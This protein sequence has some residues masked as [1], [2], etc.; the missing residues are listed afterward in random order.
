MQGVE[1]VL[2]LCSLPTTTSPA[3]S[4]GCVQE[5]LSFKIKSLFGVEISFYFPPP[6]GEPGTHLVY[7]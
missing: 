4:Q 6:A 7:A 1:Y 5:C 2:P 3:L